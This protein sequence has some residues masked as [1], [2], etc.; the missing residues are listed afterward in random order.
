MKTSEEGKRH[1]E[2]VLTKGGLEMQSVPVA[3]G[4]VA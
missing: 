3:F 2:G 4:L 1:P